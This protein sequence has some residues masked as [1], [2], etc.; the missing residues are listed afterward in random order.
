MGVFNYAPSI[1]DQM[2]STHNAL[3]REVN[4]LLY[5]RALTSPLP[6][7]AANRNK[8]IGPIHAVRIL[9][10]PAERQL[11]ILHNADRTVVN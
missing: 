7:C 10:D 4:N 5:T 6:S 11:E 1:Y 2:Y 8:L 9:G 3:F